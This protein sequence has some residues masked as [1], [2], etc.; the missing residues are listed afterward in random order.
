MTKEYMNEAF[1]E[2]LSAYKKH[3]IP[4]GAIIVFQDKIIARAG[5]QKETTKDIGGH[6]EMLALKIA[7]Q[8]LGRVNLEGCSIYTTLEPC[9]MCMGAIIQSNIRRLIFG[10]RDPSLGAVESHMKITEFPDGK[11]IQC[12]G[13][14]MEEES[15]ALIKKF[16]TRLRNIKTI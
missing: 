7:G 11:R 3:E 5:N 6:A 8:K 2:A 10:A 9:P 14:V 15:E 4:V 1:K 12:I 16:F 13:G